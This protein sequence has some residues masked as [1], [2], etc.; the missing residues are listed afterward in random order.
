M[1]KILSN[2]EKQK[3]N[4][5][6]SGQILNKDNVNLQEYDNILKI[7]KIKYLHHLENYINKEELEYR[8]ES[9]LHIREL[10]KKFRDIILIIIDLPKR[11]MNEI[12][13]EFKKELSNVKK[14]FKTNNKLKF[15]EM[16]SKGPQNFENFK[17]KKN[18][19]LLA[20]NEINEY[21][22]KSEKELLQEI[23][24]TFKERTR[25][26]INMMNNEEKEAYNKAETEVK[27]TYKK[28]KEKALQEFEIQLDKK[29]AEEKEKYRYKNIN[30][31]VL[32][33]QLK[34][35]KEEN[36]KKNKEFIEKKVEEGIRKD[37]NINRENISKKA[38]ELKQNYL[39]KCLGEKNKNIKLL[40]E[41]LKKRKRGFC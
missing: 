25:K 7:I 14:L 38:A 21:L 24:I 2:E 22:S 36:L 8:N 10:I 12:F 19:L 3:L 13:E 31:S 30:M 32:E 41:S 26:Q 39:N 16:Q 23:E 5:I 20:I 11:R 9:E 28:Q 29:I 4:N 18:Q 1:I 15:Y 27:E 17:D 6:I 37:I 33:N 34:K 35:F 40:K